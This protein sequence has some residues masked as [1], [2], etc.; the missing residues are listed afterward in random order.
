MP[1]LKVIVLALIAGVLMAMFQLLRPWGDIGLEPQE[2]A[3]AFAD[4]R[5]VVAH[6][7]GAASFVVLTALAATSSEAA[8]SRAAGSASAGRERRGGAARLAPI[9]MAVGTVLVLPYFGAE[10]FALHEL[11]R[12]ALAGS[13]LDV[14]GLSEGIR[15][16]LAA[17]AL[18]ALGLALIAAGGVC[19]AIV[20]TKMGAA[21]WGAWPLS[22]LIALA[23]PQ[24]FMP[25]VGRTIYGLVFLVAG[26]LYAL[27]VAHLGPSPRDGGTRLGA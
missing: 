4:V 10:T 6:L 24:F 18:F 17:V 12:A 11:G 13:D 14:V 16:N 1:K 27:A 22:V 7:A 9:T 23:L 2:T 19:L 25:P 21:A 3:E 20:S 8:Q 5:W 26:A 15:M